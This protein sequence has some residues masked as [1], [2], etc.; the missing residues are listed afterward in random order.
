MLS[1]LVFF[2][3]FLMTVSNLSIARDNLIALEHPQWRVFSMPYHRFQTIDHIQPGWRRGPRL[4]GSVS[5]QVGQRFCACAIRSGFS[6]ADATRLSN[7]LAL[8]RRIHQARTLPFFFIVAMA[9]GSYFTAELRGVGQGSRAQSTL[10]LIVYSCPKMRHFRRQHL[11][12][13]SFFFA[14]P[15]RLN[16]FF[17]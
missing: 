3:L 1:A 11:P 12:H 17:S 8:V 9:R 16:R 5:S 6:I 13:F 7:S 15:G 10:S 2:V 14:L 4:R